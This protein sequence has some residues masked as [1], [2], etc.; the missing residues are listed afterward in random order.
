MNERDEWLAWRRGGLGASDIAGVLGLSPWA[1]PWSIWATKVGLVEDAADSE[2]MEFGRMAEPML[3]AYF[4]DRT[5]LVVTGQQTRCEHPERPWMRCTVDGFV[6]DGP[7]R[8]IDRSVPP[9]GVV[10]FKSTSEPPWDEVPLHYQCQATWTLLVTGMERLW[11]GV[12]HLAFGRPRFRVYEFTLNPT[13]ADTIQRKAAE[14]W[15]LVEAGTPPPVDGSEATTDALQAAWGETTDDELELDEDGLSLLA[16]LTVCRRA[17]KD[18]EAKRSAYENAI[19]ERL[20]EHESGTV[21]GWKVTWKPQTRTGIDVKALR[22]EMPE[23][24]DKFATTSTT[25][26]LRVTPPKGE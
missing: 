11:F 15:A 14:F 1:S 3:A 19:R 24:A 18:Y 5:G 21:D 23:V 2:A 25:R 4:T 10:E 22:A 16:N 13:D 9:L 26:V 20:G 17:L 12:I 8:I 6:F 7:S